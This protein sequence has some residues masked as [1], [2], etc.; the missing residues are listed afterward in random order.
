MAAIRAR[1]PSRDPGLI[2]PITG[3]ADCCARAPAGH[4]AALPSPAMN[5]RRRIH[6]LF[7][8]PLW[9]AYRGR[10][11]MS[12]LDY[13]LFAAREAAFGPTRKCR[14]SAL[15]AAYWGGPAA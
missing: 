11:C 3:F 14:P 13:N 10:G 1:V 5:S 4:A 15:E 6:H 2:N 7:K 9:A 12:G 8:L